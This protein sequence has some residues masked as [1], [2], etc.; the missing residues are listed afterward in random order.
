MQG[1]PAGALAGPSVTFWGPSALEHLAGNPEFPLTLSP[2]LNPGQPRGPDLLFFPESLLRP[3]LD[4]L[5]CVRAPLTLEEEA[6][7]CWCWWGAR[8]RA[9]G[10]Y[11]IEGHEGAGAGTDKDSLASPGEV[12]GAL[13]AEG[14]AENTPTLAGQRTAGIPASAATD[15]SSVCLSQNSPG[16][17]VH[18]SKGS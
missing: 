7:R 3:A 15:P 12:S 9:P 8:E 16:D 2:G 13:R 17:T 5:F 1:C 6:E 14:W 10:L 18:G 11:L 4:L